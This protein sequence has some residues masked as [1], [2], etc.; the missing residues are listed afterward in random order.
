MLIPGSPR[1][2]SLEPLNLDLTTGRHLTFADLFPDKESRSAMAE[3]VEARIKAEPE[4]FFLE[5][6]DSSMFSESQTFLL[7]GREIVV[8]F[9]YTRSHLILRAFRSLPY[10]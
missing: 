7:K 3:V 9:G 10:L 5:G 8:F 6:F 2:D 1:H 4:I